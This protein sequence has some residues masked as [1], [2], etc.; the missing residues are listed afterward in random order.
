[1][2][3]FPHADVNSL[4]VVIVPPQLY[5][6]GVMPFTSAVILPLHCPGQYAAE[7]NV[8]VMLAFRLHSGILVLLSVQLLLFA[9]T[10][11]VRF[12]VQVVQL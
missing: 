12:L 1:M 2:Y 11:I 9:C 6:T 8:K 4:L 5:F 3:S 10:E 7:S